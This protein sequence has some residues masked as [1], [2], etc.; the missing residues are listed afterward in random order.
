M[1]FP[2]PEV[3]EMSLT[4]RAMAAG[5]GIGATPTSSRSVSLSQKKRG[6]AGE[7][8]AKGTDAKVSEVA[9]DTPRAHKEE[10]SVK[11]EVTAVL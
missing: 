1:F 6:M 10:I 2:D 9:I 3:T 5:G 4:K 11:I 7:L 8:H